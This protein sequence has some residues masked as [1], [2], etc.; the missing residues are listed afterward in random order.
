M[1]GKNCQ[2]LITADYILTQDQTRT[3]LEQGALAIGDG[4]ILAAGKAEDLAQEFTPDVRLDMGRALILPG[5]V[6]AH[7]H[8]S[9]TLLRGLADD[10][11][12]RTWLTEHIWPIESGLTQEF[13]RAGAMLAAAEMISTGCTC[14]H[15][16]Y[17]FEAAIGRAMSGMGMRAVL[18]EGVLAFPTP[19]CQTPDETFAAIE[20]QAGEFRD[21]PLITTCVA[22]HA[23]YTTSGDVLKRSFELAERLDLP[24]TIH[25]A[26]TGHEVNECLEKHGKR[27]VAYLDELGCLS[28]RSL[29]VHCVHLEDDE[30]DILAQRGCG[31][32]HQPES[33]MKLASGIARIQRLKEAGVRLCLG[34]D[35]AASNNDLNMFT[36]M[37]SASFLQKVNEMDPTALDAQSVLDMATIGGAD[38]LMRPDL[39]SLAAGKAADLAVL[40]LTRPNMTP[41]YNPVSQCVY[42][43]SGHEV[44]MTMV[45]G[46]VLYQ[47][48]QFKTFDYP[49]LLAEVES[50]RKWALARAAAK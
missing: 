33:N 19:S 36:E 13:I 40:D 11:P 16:M 24:W 9:M 39:G 50:I 2:T 14:F 38:C 10:L 48:G 42:A 35:G 34:T 23:I 17:F 49:A 15:D 1:T 3:V 26:E 41:V 4:R 45:A 18:G 44:T 43:A 31:V 25:L 37:A 22:A 47:D 32:A 5:L 8:A 29:L 6:N 28:P 27:P 46:K 21:D 12:L 7:T 20:A 30:I